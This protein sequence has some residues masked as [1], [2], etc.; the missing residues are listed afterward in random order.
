VL[1]ARLP[2]R[3]FE[4]V[5]A[6]ADG[7]RTYLSSSGE[8]VYDEAGV[9]KGYRGVGSNVTERKIAEQKLERMAQFDAVTGLANRTVLYERL[10][11]AIAQSQRRGRGAGVLYLDLDRFKLVNDT[12]GHHVGDELLMQVARSLKDCVRRDDTVARLGG[13][14]FAVVIAD[15]ARPDDAAIV[16]Q[17]I[18]DSFASP[19]DLG[20]RETFI[21]ASIGVATYPSDGERA[22]ALLKCA[23]AAM[24]RAKESSRNAFCFY[25]TEM[26]ARAASK[27]QLN[28]D[29]RRAL[30]RREFL[31]HY[32]PKV[33]LATGN[34]I[35]MEALLRWQHPERGMVSPL[36]FIP[37]LEESG[38]IVA[39]GD[40]VVA[41][42]CRQ[43]RDWSHA[44]LEPTPV[45][46]NLSARQFRRRDLDQVIRRQLAEH[47]LPPALLE[48]EITESSLMEDPKDAIRQLQ[49][50]REAGLRISVDDFGTG[51]SSLSYLTRLPLSTLKIDR[52][53]VSAAITEAGSAAI[54]KMVIDMAHRLNFDVVAEG[55]ETDRHVQFLRAHGCTQG[56][57]YH[58]GR[59]IPASVMAPRMKRRA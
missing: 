58:F 43:M 27:L 19:F 50:L 47:G 52:A 14:E 36:E 1:D 35:G 41:E 31:L 54:V 21:T 4:Q 3:D 13:D 22:E 18:L 8:P 16:A 34:M 45:A 12:L 39:V 46:V 29:L 55:I 38:L 24:Y 7:T 53:F 33:D 15:L 32:Q 56:Q 17:K 23:D 59:P 57:G 48:L 2:F 26:N 5:R 49:A 30:E 25:T 11:Q 44:G 40:W 6:N 10:E 20:G 37:A 51:Y 28:T 42:A 9:F